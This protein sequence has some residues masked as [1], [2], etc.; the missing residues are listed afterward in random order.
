MRPLWSG[1]ISF[2]LVSIPVK[3]YSMATHNEIEFDLL[4]DKCK[5]H[6]QYKKWCPKCGKAVEWKHVVRGIKTGDEYVVV[7]EEELEKI[8]PKSSKIIEI[9]KFVNQD[10]IDPIYME[11]SY[12]IVPDKSE[13]AYSLFREALQVTGKVAIGKLTLHSKEHLVMIRGFKK[14]LVLTELHY[15]DEIIDIDSLLKLKN[16][17]SAKPEELKLA[18]VL[19]EK[20]SGEFNPAEYRDEFAEALSK[21]LEGKVKVKQRNLKSEIKETK[22]LMKAL[23]ASI[24]VKK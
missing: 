9:L 16:S 18:K 11:K 23:K 1:T 6:L 10:E 2:G 14:G 20:L 22:D 3:I 17:A 12:L 15:V 5:T 21:L 4:H 24:K 19:I 13:R 7:P 8:K